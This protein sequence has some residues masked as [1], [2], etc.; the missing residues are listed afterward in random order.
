M[1]EERS[2]QGGFILCHDLCFFYFIFF[3]L[4]LMIFK[5]NCSEL[6]QKY[7]VFVERAKN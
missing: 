5:K 1:P 6:D 2:A 7:H 4:I 3:F